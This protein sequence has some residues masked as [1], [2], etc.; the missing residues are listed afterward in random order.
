[1]IIQKYICQGCGKEHERKVYSDK[2]EMAAFVFADKW[3]QSLYESTK[4]NFPG[5]AEE[6]FCR[7][8]VISA[9]YNYL[10]NKRS[11]RIGRGD[12]IADGASEKQPP[13]DWSQH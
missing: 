3:A 2:C 10:K 6:E 4:K 5:L 8:L 7:E 11:I 13:N 1:M 9:V 12:L